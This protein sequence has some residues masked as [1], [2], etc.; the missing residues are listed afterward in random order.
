MA[1]ANCIECDEEVEIMGRITLGKKVTCQ[2]CGAELEV[3]NV[4]P[5]ELDWAEE[6]YDEGWDDDDFSDE[7]DEEDE[8]IETEEEDEFDDEWK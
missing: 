5:I 3:A 4:N 1:I 7:E 6:E 8:N 2:S